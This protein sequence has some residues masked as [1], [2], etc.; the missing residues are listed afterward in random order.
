MTRVGEELVDALEALVKAEAPMEL[1]RSWRRAARLL[2]E[3]SLGL[4]AVVDALAEKSIRLYELERLATEDVLTGVAN[5]RSFDD[6][7][8]RELARRRRAGGPAV[9]MLDLDGLKEINDRF[10]HAAGD[11]AIRMAAAACL[12]Q[13][14]AGDMV[15]RLGGD[16]LA[17]LLPD[18]HLGGAEVVMERVR[19]AI[20]RQT[21]CGVRLRVSVGLAV[22]GP[23]G[24]DREEVLQAADERMY[25]DKRARKS[26]L[27]LAA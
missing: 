23:D 9:I 4:R 25:A 26:Q 8:R 18:T 5:R 13:V 22:A 16:E 7:L 12:D 14:R 27:R 24:D 20:E 2:G 10:G 1:E 15:G 3:D 17:V 11:E 19:E 21:V 6:A